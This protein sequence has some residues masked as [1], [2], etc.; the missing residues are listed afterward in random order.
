M[1]VHI[2]HNNEV[3]FWMVRFYFLIFTSTFDILFL[4][5]LAFCYRCFGVLVFRFRF[6]SNFSACIFHLNTPTIVFHFNRYAFIT[7]VYLVW[8]FTRLNNN[9]FSFPTFSTPTYTHS[10]TQTH[11]H[12]VIVMHLFIAYALTCCNW[13]VRELRYALSQV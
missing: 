12:S 3:R 8:T 7:I 6:H 11:T 5:F 13:S 9:S 4:A 1:H 10:H 2:L